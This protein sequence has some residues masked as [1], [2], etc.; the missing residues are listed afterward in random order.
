MAARADDVSDNDAMNSN[1][2]E[3]L[4]SMV[5]DHHH[6][7]PTGSGS[8][9]GQVYHEA[10]QNVL[11]AI[12]R[13]HAREKALLFDTIK[14]QAKEVSAPHRRAGAAAAAH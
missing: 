7:K 10:Y 12:Q 4:Q 2:Y 9:D 3:L 5:V 6:A 8:R 13:A 1:V 14:E 11:L